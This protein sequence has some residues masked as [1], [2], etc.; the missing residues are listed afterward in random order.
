[1]Q[2]ELNDTQAASQ[3][4]RDWNSIELVDMSLMA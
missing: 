2:E 4:S 1:M 3:S